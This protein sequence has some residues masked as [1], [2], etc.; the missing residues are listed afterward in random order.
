MA[1]VHAGFLVHLSGQSRAPQTDTNKSGTIISNINFIK[2]GIA[3]PAFSNLSS[4]SI[5]GF[6][7][8]IFPY[9]GQDSIFFS[10]F[11]SNHAPSLELIQTLLLQFCFQIYE[12]GGLVEKKIN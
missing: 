10:L 8:A 2:G 1:Q 9:S 5:L 6:L 4:Y 3:Q 7:S 11:A 12:I